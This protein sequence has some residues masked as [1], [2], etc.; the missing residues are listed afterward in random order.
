MLT[1]NNTHRGR[2]T[3]TYTPNDT[4]TAKTLLNVSHYFCQ[5][6]SNGWLVAQNMGYQQQ[7]LKVQL[8]AAYFDTDSYDSRIYAYE[9][10]LAGNFAYPVY[11]GQGFRLALSGT[12]HLNRH[13]MVAA[14]VGFT[15]YFDRSTI[16]TGLQEIAASHATD[17]DVQMRWRL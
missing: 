17:L 8:T 16:G 1:A 5:K 3:I 11:Y 10:Q 4:W 7:K 9:R 2:L 6:A 15:K 14:K 12:W 13:L